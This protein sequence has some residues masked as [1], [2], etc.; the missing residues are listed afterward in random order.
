MLQAFLF[1][2]KI[3]DKKGLIEDAG[4]SYLGYCIVHNDLL[5]YPD[6][7]VCRAYVAQAVLN[8]VSKEIRGYKYGNYSTT[9]KCCGVSLTARGNFFSQQNGTTNC[10]AH[11]AIKTA[12]RG[13][14]ENVRCENINCA[15]G[16]D[17]PNLLDKL[18]KGLTPREMR[19][20]VTKVSNALTTFSLEAN[21]MAMQEFLRTVY[22][23]IE[24]KIPVIL[25][26]SRPN[27]KDGESHAITAI[28]YTFNRHNWA[29]YGGN[30]FSADKRSYLSS[31]LWMDKL[32]IQDDNYGPLYHI[33]PN[34]FSEYV[35]YS[36]AYE[37][38]KMA[39]VSK[40]D[41][42]DP[43]WSNAPLSAMFI[44]PKE[45]GSVPYTIGHA[46]HVAMEAL[47][48]YVLTL[49][50]KKR[51]PD[52]ED[53]SLF[54]YGA[55]QAAP[56]ESEYCD[57]LTNKALI[58]RTMIISKDEYLSTNE[59]GLGDE[60]GLGDMYGTLGL[61]ETIERHLP[62]VFYM[63]EISVHELFWTNECKVGEIIIDI[64]LLNTSRE[65]NIDPVGSVKL[66]RF[67]FWLALFTEGVPYEYKIEG[68]PLYHNMA[69]KRRGLIRACLLEGYDD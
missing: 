2:K 31:W 63:T 56:K 12:L 47:E 44:L 13:Y 48:A 38:Y 52:H 50:E 29:A 46:E 53:F 58:A 9:M 16:R 66:I 35:D 43:S 34:F 64:D 45:L 62:D 24:S 55:R 54:F 65:E 67:P 26:F 19:V 10:C 61:K 17:G 27:R 23:A 6:K 39:V 59:D 69:R 28:G 3:K 33:E 25:T 21:T 20:A 8:G 30:Y 1:R 32:V 42:G 57:M 22:L 36:R 11:A 14:Y 60:E 41:L 18:G 15:I 7:K 68:M 51:L 37:R 4:E 40:T 49:G 5:V